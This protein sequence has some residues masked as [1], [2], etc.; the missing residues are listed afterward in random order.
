M[1]QVQQL[2]QQ[3]LLPPQTAAMVN[4]QQAPGGSSLEAPPKQVAL[5]M[6]RLGQ[7]ARHIADIRLGAD[8]LLEAL[9]V[10]AQ[11]HHSTKPHNVFLKEDA[12]MRQHLQDLRTIGIN[13]AIFICSCTYMDL[14]I[15][16]HI[17]MSIQYILIRLLNIYL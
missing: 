12:S 17:H 10:T 3:Q 7:A 9:F 6:E 13:T 11:P 4:S 1:Q 15:C 14:C 5:A 8:R 16:A 2:H